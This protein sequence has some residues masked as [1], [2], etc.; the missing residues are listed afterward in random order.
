MSTVRSVSVLR[1]NLLSGI[2]LNYAMRGLMLK[3]MV[4]V[5][6][7]KDGKFDLIILDLMMPK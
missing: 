4:L 1:R 3:E 6:D 2:E 7:V 5:C